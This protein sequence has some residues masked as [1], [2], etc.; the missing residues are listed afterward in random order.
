M[1]EIKEQ[2]S[3][4]WGYLRLSRQVASPSTPC[5]GTF[6]TS[7]ACCIMCKHSWH[8]WCRV[9]LWTNFEEKLKEVIRKKLTWCLVSQ[10]LYD[11]SCTALPFF[12]LCVTSS[13]LI[14]GLPLLF[15]GLPS[16]FFPPPPRGVTEEVF[17]ECVRVVKNVCVWVEAGKRASALCCQP[18]WASCCNWV[19]GRERVCACASVCG[20]ESE[21]GRLV[22]SLSTSGKHTI[23]SLFLLLFFFFFP[24][25]QVFYMIFTFKESCRMFPLFF[26]PSVWVSVFNL[27]CCCSTPHPILMLWLPWIINKL[28]T[29]PHRQ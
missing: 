12:F 21:R 6:Y 10:N 5:S 11:L 26:I 2:A 7:Y 4:I 18:H 19:T 1:L 23:L 22:H 28:Q 8:T 24:S 27:I 20:T 3:E 25:H 15:A 14:A 17:V 16:V 13:L 9:L 29:K